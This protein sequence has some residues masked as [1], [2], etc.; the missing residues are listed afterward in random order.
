MWPTHSSTHIEPAIHSRAAVGRV[1]PCC[2]N[3]PNF[4]LNPALYV[5]YIEYTHTTVDTVTRHSSPT[6]FDQFDLND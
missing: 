2:C 1:E 3:Q 4:G 6:R 5:Y